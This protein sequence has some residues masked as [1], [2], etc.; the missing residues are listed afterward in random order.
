MIVTSGG[1][2]V[3]RLE[4]ETATTGNVV[5]VRKVTPQVL[6]SGIPPYEPLAETAV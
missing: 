1:N 6:M 2:I 5:N 4:E 3:S